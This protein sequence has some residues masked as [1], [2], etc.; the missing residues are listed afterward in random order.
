MSNPR[1][2]C[3]GEILFDLLA[4][5]IGRSLDRVESWTAYPGGAPANVACALTRLGSTSGFIGCIGGDE[6]GNQLVQVLQASG[7]DVSGVQRHKTAPTRQVY[8]VR[9]ETG[10]RIFAGFGDLDTTEFADTQLQADGLP[11]KLFAGADFLVL[12]TIALAYPH[13]Q[14]SVYRALQLAEQYN[15]KVVLDINWRSVFWQQ[16]TDTARQIIHKIFDKIDFLKL[17]KEEAQLLFDTIDPGAI[18]YRLNSLEG[19]IITDGENGCSY[20]LSENEGKVP[21]F[22]VPVIDTTGAGDSFVAGFVH[23]LSQLGIGNLSDP[24]IAKKVVTYASAAGA[25]TTL[26]P[27]AIASQPTAAE[28]EA[29]LGS[30]PLL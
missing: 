8:V 17:S 25:L 5:Q 18:N 26:K 12:G 29:F 27:G 7:V 24:A 10:D 20:C 3:L 14:A 19:V 9:T 13:S 4:D 2:L 11:E 16:D 6:P 15:I 22:S 28:I 23:Q 30:Q 21:A 1:I